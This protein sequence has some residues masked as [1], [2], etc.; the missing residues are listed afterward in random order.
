MSK[1]R[2]EERLKLMGLLSISY[3]RLRRDAIET[4]KYLHGIYST[5]TSTLLPLAPFHSGIQTR[6]HS[7]KLQK[8]ECRLSVRAN[9]L[10]FRIV[11][12]WNFM[13]EDIITAPSINI[14]KGRFDKEYI[15]IYYVYRTQSTKY[16]KYTHKTYNRHQEVC[17]PTLLHWHRLRRCMRPYSLQVLRPTWIER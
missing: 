7:P 1:L 6:G 8:R 10:G 5:N 11:N 15:I 3:R 16:N 2:Y 13:P 17:L 4:F 14:F 9:V 12:I